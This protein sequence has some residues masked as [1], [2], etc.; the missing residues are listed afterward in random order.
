MSEWVG[1]RTAQTFVDLSTP[2]P[3]VT[4]PQLI[5]DEINAA[6]ERE[7]TRLLFGSLG[8]QKPAKPEPMFPI[9]RRVLCA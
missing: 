9:V 4:V 7:L 3:G 1:F 2:L 8:P 6:L 5:R